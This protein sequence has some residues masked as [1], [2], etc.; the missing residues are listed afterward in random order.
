[1]GK[2]CPARPDC[3]VRVF[4]EVDVGSHVVEDFPQ[5]VVVQGRL[6][7]PTAESEHSRPSDT[8]EGMAQAHLLTTIC[9]RRRDMA[10]RLT[11]NDSGTESQA[12]TP[13]A[14]SISSYLRHT[15]LQLEHKSIKIRTRPCLSS[16]T[17][18]SPNPGDSLSLLQ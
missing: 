7:H 9:S 4:V 18:M 6:L 2:V 15:V 16:R 8:V 1:M 10:E 12:S 5:Y 3:I 13:R 17:A 11:G 14:P